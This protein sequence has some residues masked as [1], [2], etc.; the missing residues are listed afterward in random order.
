VEAS[1]CWGLALAVLGHC[2]GHQ[3]VDNGYHIE[4]GS[5]LSDRYGDT[6]PIEAHAAAAT[7][8]AVRKHAALESCGVEGS[9]RAREVLI[10]CVMSSDWGNH[11]SISDAYEELSDR[12]FGVYGS[13][14][15]AKLPSIDDRNTF[16]VMMLHTSVVTYPARRWAVASKWADALAAE[17]LAQGDE[18]ESLG[19]MVP[20]HMQ[21]QHSSPSQ[22]A[23]NHLDNFVLPS[24]KLLGSLVP[25]VRDFAHTAMENRALFQKATAGDTGGE[26][27]ASAPKSKP[28]VD[29]SGEAVPVARFQTVNMPEDNL[30]RVNKKEKMQRKEGELEGAV[31]VAAAGTGTYYQK[32]YQSMAYGRAELNNFIEGGPW[33]FLSLSMTILALFLDQ[34]RDAAMPVS[35]DLMVNILLFVSFIF[36]IVEMFLMSLSQ[37]GYFLSFFFW[38]DFAGTVSLILD[39]PFLFVFL[40][41]DTA[42]EE[43]GL[44]GGAKAARG[45]RAARA[46]KMARLVRL[47]RL[48]R[49]VRLLKFVAHLGRK[50]VDDDGGEESAAKPSRIGEI[51]AEQ[52]SQ[53]VVILVLLVLF[54]APLLN[55]EREISYPVTTLMTC[56]EYLSEDQL[57][58]FVAK[59]LAPRRYMESSNFNNLLYLEVNGAVVVAEDKELMARI[60]EFPTDN[61]VYFANSET[62][63]GCEPGDSTVDCTVAMFDDRK[64]HAEEGLMGI[65]LIIF[66]VRMLSS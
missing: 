8:A 38:L 57:D 22:L 28:V 11:P 58:A 10:K 12:T 35:A 34:W 40:N 18:L 19:L 42:S 9:R 24:L 32:C 25:R 62:K 37:K 14:K 29:A 13:Q 33:Q 15:D 66:M 63:L 52:M 50:K 41:L 23:M 31:V 48:V 61:E 3:G 26:T 49:F 64:F 30:N 56:L 1:E 27:L 5:A 46:T 36:F 16:C 39:I 2:A 65:Y 53:R 44:V 55:A 47:I 4:V 7:L 17:L 59:E 21:R 20:P 45:A 54:I 60:R 51:L 43:I 6:Q